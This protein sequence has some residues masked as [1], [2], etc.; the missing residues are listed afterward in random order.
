MANSTIKKQLE[1]TVKMIVTLLAE[2]RMSA[3]ALGKA[4][5]VSAAWVHKMTG[6][7]R[8]SGLDIEFDRTKNQ[9]SVGLSEDLAKGLLGKYANR[10]KRSI[11]SHELKNPPIRFVT[12]LERYDVRQFSEYLGSSPQNVYNMIAGYKGQ[13]LPIGWV[14]Y[15]ISPSGKWFI[16]KMNTDRSGKKHLLPDNVKDAHAHVIGI[17]AQAG[18]EG[19]KPEKPLCEFR[20]CKEISMAKG[21]CSY[22]Y[23]KIRRDP[24]L[25]KGN[26]KSDPMGTPAVRGSTQVRR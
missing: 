25:L 2:P 13:G 17:N 24:K 16:Q 19:K 14:A 18:P 4:L 26:R 9:Y 3:E 15:Q 21:L 12:S 6:I 10:L 20:G 7:L 22:H 5:G 11:T 23:Y 8:E 1:L